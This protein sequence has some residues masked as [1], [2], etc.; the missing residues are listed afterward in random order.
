MKREEKLR[1]CAGCESERWST[2]E[3]IGRRGAER[4]ASQKRAREENAASAQLTS[5]DGHGLAERENGGERGR[6]LQ[7]GHATVRGQSM[8]SVS[9]APPGTSGERT[10]VRLESL[11]VRFEEGRRFGRG[12]RG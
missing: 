12:V 2:E 1:G 5:L 9:R 7:K 4:E 10:H 3:Q 8:W 11:G 6:V